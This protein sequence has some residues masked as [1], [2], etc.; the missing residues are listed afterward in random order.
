MVATLVLAMQ[1]ILGG[2]TVLHL[3]AYWS[4][5]L[6]LLTGNLFMVLIALLAVRLAPAPA[7]NPMPR[8]AQRIAVALVAALVV[9]MALGGLV[10]S[11]LAGLACTEWPTCN[12]GV[13][14]PVFDGIVGLHLVHRLGA[15][16]LLAVS[17]AFWAVTGRRLVFALVLA[18][19]AL[20]VA[21]V[22]LAMPVEVAILHSALAD[23]V[24]LAT[25]VAVFGVL[26][27]PQMLRGRKTDPRWVS[28]EAK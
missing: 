2:L 7:E 23:L 26:R 10:S 12:G 3:L 11:N 15:Y 1:V 13:W 27:Q 19:G 20:G 14:F 16:T 24:V 18:Q 6:H 4:V 17:A 5:T 8:A 28:V 22:L 25:M 21:N 9:Q